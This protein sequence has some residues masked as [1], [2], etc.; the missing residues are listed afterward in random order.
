MSL[1]RFLTSTL[2]IVTALISQPRGTRQ[3]APERHPG[4]TKDYFPDLRARHKGAVWSP[5]HSPCVQPSAFLSKHERDMQMNRSSPERGGTWSRASHDR[6]ENDGV[7]QN[8]RSL[9]LCWNPRY[10]RAHSG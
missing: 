6:R 7:S 9:G 3:S 5:V 10:E 4:R 8:Q 2:A 1:F